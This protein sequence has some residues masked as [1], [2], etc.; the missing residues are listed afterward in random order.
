MKPSASRN[1][2]PS[3]P[4]PANDALVFGPMTAISPWMSINPSVC[5]TESAASCWS[6]VAS[7]ASASAATYLFELRGALGRR[8]HDH[9]S[10]EDLETDVGP[11]HGRRGAQGPADQSPRHFA[12]LARDSLLHCYTG[13]DRAS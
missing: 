11:R 10:P 3:S 7:E 2:S 1:C 4:R 6:R 12:A 8:L 5:G 9:H 13:H